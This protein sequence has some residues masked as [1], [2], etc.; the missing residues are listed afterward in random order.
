MLRFLLGLAGIELN[1]LARRAATTALLLALG[2]LLLGVALVALLVA[3]FIALANAYDPVVAALLVAAIC[4]IGAIILLVV[5]YVRMRRRS[6]SPAYGISP[7][8]GLRAP[9]PPPATPFVGEPPPPVGP[10]LKSSTVIGIAA[11]AALLGLILGRR[12]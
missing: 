1:Y 7:F 10:P 6:R 9:M 4:F 5:G 12:I 8:A 3:I 11:G 2:G